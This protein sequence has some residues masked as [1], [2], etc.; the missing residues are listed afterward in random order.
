MPVN[1]DA[2]GDSP[3]TIQTLV[4]R[5]NQL[6]RMAQSQHPEYNAGAASFF[7]IQAEA[8]LYYQDLDGAETLIKHARNF[9]VEFNEKIGDP[10]RLEKLLAI[11]RSSLQKQAPAIAANDDAV[12]RVRRLIS[13]AQLAFDRGQYNEAQSL[14]EDAKKLN[15]D[16]D[17]LSKKLS[18][19]LLSRLLK[20]MSIRK[21]LDR[22]TK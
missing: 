2:L 7:L 9:N 5:Q 1:F 17:R 8:L 21:S 13:Q 14:I 19:A 3:R 15:V 16:E 6:A 11:S 12:T 20:L 18:V 10:D 22:L 4:N